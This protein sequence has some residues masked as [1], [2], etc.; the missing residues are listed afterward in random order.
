MT[1]QDKLISILKEF[2]STQAELIKSLQKKFPEVFKKKY[3]LQCP[4]R[5]FIVYKK[6]K[7]FF[8][9]HGAGVSFTSEISKKVVDVHSYIEN[10]PKCFDS[11]RVLQYLESLPINE[12]QDFLNKE[13]LEE[14]NIENF[15]NK[16]LDLKILGVNKKGLY[17]F[18]LNDIEEIK[19][20][21]LCQ[22]KTDTSWC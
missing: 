16:L 12:T 2:V 19:K 14:E 6:E 5:G 8:Q 3:L 11:W 10:Y 9:K 20:N 13:T 7:W 18:S 21:Y 4:R 1:K 22:N 15:L 17:F